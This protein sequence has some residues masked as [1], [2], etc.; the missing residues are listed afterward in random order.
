VITTPFNLLSLTD[1][2]LRQSLGGFEFVNYLDSD[3]D[4]CL[5]MTGHDAIYY[6]IPLVF[7]ITDRD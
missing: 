3:D 1:M 6:S 2:C 7:R 5:F 4:T